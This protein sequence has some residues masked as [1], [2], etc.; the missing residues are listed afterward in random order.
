M[1]DTT[2]KGLPPPPKAY[3]GSG[4]RIAVVHARWNDKIINALLAGT[5]AKLRQQGVRDE[6]IVVKTVAGSYELPLACKK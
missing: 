5:L 4:L 2:V 6:N 3:D 1:L